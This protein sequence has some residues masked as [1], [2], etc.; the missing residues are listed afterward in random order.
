MGAGDDYA[1]ARDVAHFFLIGHR[2]DRTLVGIEHA[3]LDLG[4]VGQD[5]AAPTAG[6]CEVATPATILATRSALPLGLE[7]VALWRTTTLEHH[8]S[9]CL[10]G[11]ASHH[12]RELLERQTVGGAEL[13]DQLDRASISI[14]PEHRRGLR[15][16]LSGRQG[17]FLL[18]GPRQRG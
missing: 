16:S 4:G 14:V 3:K 8:V 6:T 7:A 1:D 11:H 17:P 12:C 2:C 9:V 18:D 13:R 15:T 10:L 5:R